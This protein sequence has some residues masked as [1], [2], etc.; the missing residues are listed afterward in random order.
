MTSLHDQPVNIVIVDDDEDDRFLIDYA[1]TTLSPDIP[2]CMVSAARD[3]SAVLKTCHRQLSLI[4][5]LNIPYLNGVELVQGKPVLCRKADIVIACL[6]PLQARQA[7]AFGAK[8]ELLNGS[9]SSPLC[10]RPK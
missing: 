4:T 7:T 8:Q 10:W 3:A 9:A 2:V 5:D 6:A 1:L